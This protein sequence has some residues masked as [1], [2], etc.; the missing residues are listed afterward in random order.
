MSKKQKTWYEYSQ[1]HGKKNMATIREKQ[2]QIKRNIPKTN[3][4]KSSLGNKQYD[5]K[6]ENEK[7]SGKNGI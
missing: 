1:R 2:K 4:Q 5:G 6:N 7:V 3:K